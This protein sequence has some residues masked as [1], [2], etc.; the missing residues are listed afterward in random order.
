MDRSTVQIR[1]YT[2]RY[3]KRPKAVDPDTL[4][5]TMTIEDLERGVLALGV[6]CMPISR[7]AFIKEARH[8]LR[9]DPVTQEELQDI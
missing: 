6:G 9:Q 4:T 2:N 8:L 3:R 5:L 1:L 7:R